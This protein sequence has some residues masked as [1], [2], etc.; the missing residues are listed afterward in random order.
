MKELGF[1]LRVCLSSE[2]KLFP[3]YSAAAVEAKYIFSNENN[4]NSFHFCAIFPKYKCSLL[5]T[6]LQSREI[7]EI[8]L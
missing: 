2:P 3:F 6:A 4:S 5:E 8:I 1:K 7:V